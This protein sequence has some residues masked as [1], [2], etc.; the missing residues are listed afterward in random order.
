MK[1]M[2]SYYQ[3]KKVFVTGHTGFKGSWLCHILS[4]WGADVLGYSNGLP[5]EPSLFEL[6]GTEKLVRSE[7]G[8]IRDFEHL[9]KTYKSFLPDIVI[10]LAAQPL[11]RESYADPRYTYETNVMG[12]V[13]LLECIRLYPSASSVLN[14]TTDK[15]YENK[16]WEWGYREIEALNGFDAY[17]NSK[18]CS[19]IATQS[20]IKSFFS[21]ETSPAISIA[22]AGNVIGGGDFSKDRIIPDSVGACSKNEVIHVR[23]PYSIRPYQH[24]L[25]PLS[26][27]LW[28]IFRQASDHSL[29]DCYNVGPN[30][31]DCVTTGKLVSLFCEAWGEGAKWE[32]K[33]E[34]NAVHE[35]NFLKLDCSK[36]KSRLGWYPIWNIDNA[37]YNTVEWSKA[38]LAGEN[39][40]NVMARQI[41]K[42]FGF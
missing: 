9:S 34:K 27:Y 3:G 28:I 8:D 38:W 11:V 16:E 37:V 17:S 22:R 23:N 1:N 42:Y 35:A 33:A 32:T 10:H 14:V 39:V 12:T 13:N 19:D 6:S 30:E 25:E 15:V 26:A 40:F 21:R 2:V 24:V 36:I 29:A 5:T 41:K 4:S 31:D 7:I 18:S 20:Y